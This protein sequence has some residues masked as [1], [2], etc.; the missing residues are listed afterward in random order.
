MNVIHRPGKVFHPGRLIIGIDPDLVGSGV[1]LAKD[2]RL[3]ELHSIPFPQLL[4]SAQQWASEQ[5]LFV[6]EDVEHHATTYRRAGTNQR[7]HARIAQNVG[8]VKATA[9]ILV[10]CLQHM[11]A[12]VQQVKPLA[13]KRQAKKNADYFSRLTGWQGRTNED[14]RDAGLLALYGVKP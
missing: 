11:G 10:E 14:K 4:E 13:G 2:G 5:A 7:Q 1:A 6:V 3:L 12:E 9:R 8:Q